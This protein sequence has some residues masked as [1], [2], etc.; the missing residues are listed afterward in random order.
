MSPSV[1]GSALLA[2]FAG[3]GFSG[4]ALA[5]NRL[6]LSAL[7]VFFA[8]LAIGLGAALLTT[9]TTL[10]AGTLLA[11]G[12]AIAA[13]VACVGLIQRIVR[14][15]PALPPAQPPP[16]D[17]VVWRLEGWAPEAKRAVGHAQQIADAHHH[18]HVEIEHLALVLLE[19]RAPNASETVAEARSLLSMLPTSS[20][21][22]AL[23]P[24]L[25]SVLGAVEGQRSERA[26]P[27]LE[28]LW[29]VVC[30]RGGEAARLLTSNEVRQE[31]LNM[32]RS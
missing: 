19:A 8:T 28:T 15:K 14:W 13:G 20:L 11:G 27:S 4:Q 16:A 6:E 32:V 23:A 10:T 9:T 17:T 21:P 22:A 24:D 7:T 29:A 31:R 1:R 2:P 30:A 26:P 25:Q 18:A 5:V 3:P 12:C